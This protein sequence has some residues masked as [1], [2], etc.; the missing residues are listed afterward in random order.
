MTAHQQQFETQGDLGA[1]DDFDALEAAL[2]DSHALRRLAM[3]EEM[4]EVGMVLMRDLKR[5]TEAAPTDDL[6]TAE[7][8][9]KTYGRLTRSMRLNL[10]LDAKMREDLR[11]RVD[12]P[13]EADN[14][15]SR[16]SDKGYD[17]PAKTPI[18]RAYTDVTARGAVNAIINSAIDDQ[19]KDR[20]EVER[21]KVGLYERLYDSEDYRELVGT[22]HLSQVLEAICQDL[23]VS[24]NL[25]QWTSESWAMGAL[26][27]RP[28]QPPGARRTAPPEWS[29]DLRARSPR[30]RR[31]QDHPP[32]DDNPP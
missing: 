21:L 32:P 5:L 23:G 4:A 11:R 26:L 24:L 25:S 10:A 13:E 7:E 15:A 3:I 29:P 1:P 12:P 17:D 2:S 31:D 20:G 14:P 19:I 18:A 6:A 27:S 8:R 16:W 30:G 22:Y 9:A 28:V